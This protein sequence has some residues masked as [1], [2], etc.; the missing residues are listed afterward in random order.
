MY[1]PRLYFTCVRFL[2]MCMF[3]FSKCTN[4]KEQNVKMSARFCPT[5][6]YIRLRWWGNLQCSILL[7]SCV[8]RKE[9][10]PSSCTEGCKLAEVQIG[11]KLWQMLGSC[12][13]ASDDD[14]A[15]HVV[16]QERLHDTAFTCR[17][18]LWKAFFDKCVCCNVIGQRT[19]NRKVLP[20]ELISKLHYWSDYRKPSSSSISSRWNA[21][22]V[23]S[24]V[25]KACDLVCL[26]S[27]PNHAINGGSVLWESHPQTG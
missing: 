18:I 13:G 2:K 14:W 10:W 16:N 7:H 19:Q 26:T 21:P 12:V 24:R 5:I 27:S 15:C 4:Y 22:H 9:F 20:M 25:I 6:F 8:R 17:V 3:I 23:T 11:T 1:I